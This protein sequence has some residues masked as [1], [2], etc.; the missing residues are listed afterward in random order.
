M[1]RVRRNPLNHW[2]SPAPFQLDRVT[3]LASTLVFKKSKLDHVLR[4]LVTFHNAATARDWCFG[5]GETRWSLQATIVTLRSE[6][7]PGPTLIMA[8]ERLANYDERFPVN[9]DLCPE[10][11]VER[12]SWQNALSA[13]LRKREHPAP[14][15]TPS[16]AFNCIDQFDALPARLCQRSVLA[17]LR[18]IQPELTLPH[19]LI[20]VKYAPA[21]LK[22]TS[23]LR[24][25]FANLELIRQ[26]AVN[27]GELA[28]ANQ[29]SPKQLENAIK[30]SR[31]ARGCGRPRNQ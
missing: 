22:P 27:F 1:P 16:L 3:E 5:G 30:R 11:V 12:L 18:Q 29:W 2:A 25:A 13:E 14:D 10:I 6:I 28:A 20:L 7:N 26:E 31:G 24:D 21:T 15:R 19:L 23:H 9:S 8:I 17:D 4:C